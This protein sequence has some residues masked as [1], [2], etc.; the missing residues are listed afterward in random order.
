MSPA[1]PPFDWPALLRAG[2][3]TLRLRPAEFWALTPAELALMLGLQSRAP[4][5]TRSRLSEL[6]ERFPDKVPPP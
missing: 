6:L 5:M 4:A 2:L 3:Q 1:P